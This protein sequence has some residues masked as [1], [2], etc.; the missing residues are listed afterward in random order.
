MY[1]IDL[2]KQSEDAV[3]VLCDEEVTNPAQDAANQV[4]DEFK[5]HKNKARSS[6]CT[7]T[8]AVKSR[9]LYIYRQASHY[10]VSR[11]IIF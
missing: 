7:Y 2:Q 5:G 11:A 8:R 9:E 3:P 4:Q 10:T 6:I 1:Q